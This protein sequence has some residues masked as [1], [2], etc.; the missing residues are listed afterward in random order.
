MGKK[1]N[2]TSS[3]THYPSFRA[4]ATATATEDDSNDIEVRPTKT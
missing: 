3:V 1:S 2:D 4:I